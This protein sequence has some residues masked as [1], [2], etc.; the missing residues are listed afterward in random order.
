[1]K[2]RSALVFG[3][4]FSLTTNL[5]A[6]G[7]DAK[8]ILLAKT[9]LIIDTHI[10]VPNRL[11][12][13]YE[14]VSKA[15]ENGDFDYPRAISGGLNA[16]FMSIYIP[17]ELEAKGED[18]ALANQLIDDVENLIQQAPD[19]FYK[20]CSS[21]D[22]ESSIKLN[23][24]ALPMGLENGSPLAG[25]LK[26][27]EHFWNR[28]I[29][30]ITL[31]HSKSNHISDSSYDSHRQ[32]YGLSDFGKQLIPEMN[33]LGVMVD[34][35]HI[36][37]IAFYQVMEISKAPVIAS[38]SSARYF[39]PNFE[40]NMSDEMI[41]KLAQHQGVIQVTFGSS[42]LD[43]SA[44][45]AW[46]VFEEEEKQFVRDNTQL[47]P[48]SAEVEEFKK[49]YKQQHP[50]LW[51]SVDRVL[52]HI[53]HIVKLTSIDN[54]GIGSDYEGVGDSLPVGLKDVSSYPNLI[55]GLL[56][57]GYDETA[58]EKILSGNVLRVWK[59]VEQF[60][61]SQGTVTRHCLNNVGHFN[62]K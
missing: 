7:M 37:D 51:V 33:K 50:E 32:W 42:F 10:D 48:K 43:Q 39:T 55:K 54:V 19:K 52:D 14:D 6:D 4:L 57:R 25:D 46:D 36:T 58:I 18:T 13:N 59:A 24:I 11:R 53:D 1:M 49:Q 21:A 38:H 23:K 5:V 61:A 3:I 2:K 27:L 12:K 20:A 56:K 22:V 47:E 8:A 9:L 34:V 45:D 28:G 60:A 44:R 35:S 40:R 41:I 30:Y 15:T 17:A 26:N 62:K 29:R 16:P 31:A